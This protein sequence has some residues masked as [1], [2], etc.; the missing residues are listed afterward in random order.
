MN[1]ALSNFAWDNQNSEEVFKVLKENG[2]NQIECILTK[3]KSWDDTLD[4]INQM[5]IVV[6]S[7]TSL[8]HAAGSMGKDSIVI[9]PILTYYT[10]AKPG[11]NTKWYANN[12][13]VLRQTDY[14]NWNAPL[15]EFKKLL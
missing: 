3:I 12:L 13:K 4:Y 14:D 9:V 1:L 7:C 8:I 11:I 5:D 6:S 10:W 2:I 15:D